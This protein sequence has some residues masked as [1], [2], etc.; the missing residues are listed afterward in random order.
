MRA[1]YLAGHYQTEMQR[2]MLEQRFNALTQYAND[3]ILL[4][5]AEGRIVEVNDRAVETFGFSREELLSLEI[6]DLRPAREKELSIE[7]RQ[8]LQREGALLFE[9]QFLKRDGTE[10]PAEVSSRLIELNNEIYFQGILRDITERKKAE[11][12]IQFLAHHDA[13]TGLPNRTLLQDRLG[14]SLARAHRYKNRVA[15][16][17]LDFDRFKNNQRFT[18]PFHWRQLTA[19]SR[20]TAQD[21]YS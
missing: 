3:I 12:Q 2:Q 10:F 9:A 21:L 1:S 5:S 14:Q 16:L 19:G 6:S 7:Q 8:R 4:V 15:I 17:F 11:A 20:R 18:R 13:L